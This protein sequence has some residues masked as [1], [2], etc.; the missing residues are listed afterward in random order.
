MRR[1]HASMEHESE[2][3]YTSPSTHDQEMN[4][5]DISET[6]GAFPDRI[7][8]KVCDSDAYLDYSTPSRYIKP[9]DL[10]G[11]PWRIAFALQADGWWLRQDIIWDKGNPMP[12]SVKDRCCKSHEYVFLLTKSAKYYFDQYAISEDSSSTENLQCLSPDI[13]DKLVCEKQSTERRPDRKMQELFGDFEESLEPEIQQKSKSTDDGSKIL[14]LRKGTKDKK[15]IQETLRSNRGTENEIPFDEKETRKNSQIQVAKET[16]RPERKG[17]VD[18]S[19]KGQ[20]IFFERKGAMVEA[21]NRIKEKVSNQ[22][23]KLHSDD[24]RVEPSQSKP[25]SQ[26]RILRDNTSEIGK[27]S[28]DTFVERGTSYESQYSS[29]LQ[30]MQRKEGQST[31]KR[32]R[33]SVWH[34]NTQSYSQ[35]HFATFPE[36]IPEICIK[37]GTSAEGCCGKC[38]APL[39]RVIER[40]GESTTEKSKRLGN[41]NK[42]G[43]GGKLVTQSLDYSGRHDSNIR[44]V[45]TIAWQPTCKCSAEKV[46]CIVLDCFS[47]SG[48]TG[49][50]AVKLGRRYIGIDLNKKYL[51]LAKKRI[52]LWACV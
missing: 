8:D 37:A 38:G 33:R 26:M 22:N 30:E 27:G 15:S 11:I 40:V 29:S 44:E 48:T 39:E 2:P 9:K 14:S 1:H 4:T 50:V 7:S 34:I 28:Q 52:G 13:S 17:Q 51:E 23:R 49:E 31:A 21:K 19:K 16:L 24:G 47:G 35:S 20:E 46:P 36:A 5:G 12:E 45:E 18:E 43:D 42:R 25:Q 3:P 6:D 10:C 32:I 41:D